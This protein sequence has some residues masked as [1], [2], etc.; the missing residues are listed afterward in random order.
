MK[1][2]LKL[3]SLAIWELT[4][5]TLFIISAGLLGMAIAYYIS[6]WLI[7]FIFFFLLM[8]SR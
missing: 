5:K 1:E 4:W 6:P 3:L 7:F 8:P 2:F